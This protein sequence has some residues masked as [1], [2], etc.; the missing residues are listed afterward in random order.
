MNACAATGSPI[1]PSSIALRHV[2]SPAPRK[3][4]LVQQGAGVAPLDGERLLVVD[5]LPGADGVE[6]DGGVGLGDGEV[7]HQLDVRVPDEPSGGEHVRHAVLLGG[8]LRALLVEIRDGDDLRAP[9]PPEV[10]QVDPADIPA[11]DDPDA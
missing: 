2:W 7:Q 4:R 10:L 11:P 6:G 8:S 9:V 5:V 3:L 1:S